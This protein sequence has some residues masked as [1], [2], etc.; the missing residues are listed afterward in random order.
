MAESA[1]T[2]KRSAAAPRSCLASPPLAG[3]TGDM[4]AVATWAGFGPW[5]KGDGAEIHSPLSTIDTMQSQQERGDLDCDNG[6]RQAILDHRPEFASQLAAVPMGKAR[7]AV[8]ATSNWWAAVQAEPDLRAA[9]AMDPKLSTQLGALAARDE[10]EERRRRSEKFALRQIRIEAPQ[11]LSSASILEVEQLEA[12]DRHCQVVLDNEFGK[13]LLGC[14]PDLAGQLAGFPSGKLRATVAGDPA[15]L[16]LV[17]SDPVL[18]NFAKFDRILSFAIYEAFTPQDD[19]SE[20]ASRL[21]IE[22]RL[23]RAAITVEPALAEQIALVPFQRMAEFVQCTDPLWVSLCHDGYGRQ[24]VADD[25]ALRP[26]LEA[27]PRFTESIPDARSV[28]QVT[29]SDN[30]LAALRSEWRNDPTSVHPDIAA[31]AAHRDEID[32]ANATEIDRCFASLLVTRRPDC[33][34]IVRSIG[35]GQ[36]R[37]TLVTEPAWRELIRNDE[38]LARFAVSDVVLDKR[39]FIT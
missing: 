19:Q 9:A 35:L 13:L 28:V 33:A 3:A 36:V 10:S 39:I 7:E 15:W 29:H 38:A 6:F 5:R 16:E 30:T 31:W 24:V 20:L 32:A 26:K 1:V 11:L 22:C 21:A 2:A 14:R 17:V 12:R 8:L 27:D 25:K 18:F 37:L 34:D 4:G 23:R